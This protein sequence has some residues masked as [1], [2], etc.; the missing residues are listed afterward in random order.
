[1][2]RL[3]DNPPSE[4][5]II[6]ECADWARLRCEGV[7]PSIASST[8]AVFTTSWLELTSSFSLPCCSRAV[9]RSTRNAQSKEAH[10]TLLGVYLAKRQ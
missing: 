1:M 2:A 4:A 6:A 10:F 8:A 3:N 9:S 7:Q 5:R